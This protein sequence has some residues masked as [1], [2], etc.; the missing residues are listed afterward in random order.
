[1]KSHLP[2]ELLLPVITPLGDLSGL[3]VFVWQF[4]G[5]FVVLAGVLLMNGTQSAPAAALTALAATTCCV[6][7]GLRRTGH[8]L[9]SLPTRLHRT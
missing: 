3:R 4:D 5:L 2:V 6:W 7:A 8:P 9:H 1:M